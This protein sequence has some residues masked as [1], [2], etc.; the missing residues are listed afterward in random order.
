MALIT[1][2]MKLRGALADSKLPL[3]VVG[4]DEARQQRKAMRAQLD[5]YLLPRLRLDAPLLRWSAVR[6]A[7]ASRRWSTPC[8]AGTSPPTACS[9]RR[10]APLC[11]CT[12]PRTS[13]VRGQRIL[14]GLARV[15]GDWDPGRP[16]TTPAPA[17][18][19]D[20]T[21]PGGPRSTPR[22]RLGGQGQP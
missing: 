22:H 5:D 8:W 16:R 9:G 21:A 3:D 18:G 2:L 20:P 4:A 10:P 15:T 13:V 11:W 6:R 1:A 7:R 19:R 12:A 17:A 14:P